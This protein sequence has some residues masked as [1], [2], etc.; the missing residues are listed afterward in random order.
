MLATNGGG[1][2]VNK[3]LELKLYSNDFLI[4]LNS[5]FTGGIMSF[6]IYD[7]DANS[8]NNTVRDIRIKDLVLSIVD[9]KG[10]EYKN[11]DVEY[12]G[13]MDKNFK[14]E[15]DSITLLQGTSKIDSPIEKGSLMGNNG[16]YFYLNE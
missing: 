13:Y 5:G 14:N 3:D 6:E 8:I 12:V 2:I 15:G 9:A 10:N 16:N 4:P 11:S 1:G 7:F